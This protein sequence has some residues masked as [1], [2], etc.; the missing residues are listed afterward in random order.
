M[1]CPGDA[2][3][4]IQFGV[5]LWGGIFLRIPVAPAYLAKAVAAESGIVQMQ[6]T[7][8]GLHGEQAL[9]PLDGFGENPG[10]AHDLLPCCEVI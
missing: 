6:Q 9:S 10:Q 4:I 5:Q 2:T 1:I 3:Q 8:A 7:Y